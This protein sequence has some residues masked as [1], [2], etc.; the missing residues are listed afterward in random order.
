MGTPQKPAPPKKPIVQNGQMIFGSVGGGKYLSL[1]EV[2]KGLGISP[3]YNGVDYSKQFLQ[4]AQPTVN[5]QVVM[6]PV[7]KS[8]E[9]ADGISYLIGQYPMLGDYLAQKFQ[10]TEG[11]KL[12]PGFAEINWRSIEAAGG[13]MFKAVPPALASANKEIANEQQAI[14]QL[15]NNLNYGIS[16]GIASATASQQ[17]NAIDNIQQTIE[18]WYGAAFPEMTQWLTNALTGLITQQG[19][20]LINHYALMDV[21]RGEVKPPGMSDATFS[22]I[23]QDYET[24]FPGLVKYNSGKGNVRMSEKQYQDYTQSIMNVATQY[25]APMPGRNQIAEILNH[26]I[27]A[28]EYTQRVQDI[29]SQVINADAGTRS[30]L[31]NEFGITHSDLMQYMLTGETPKD[32]KALGLPQMQRQVATAEI[33]D[34]ANRVGLKGLSFSGATDLADMAKLA[35]TAGNQGLAYGVNQIEQGVLGASRDVALTRSLPGANT[36]TLNTNTLLASQLAGFGGINQV[37]AQTEVARAEQ[38]KVAP[39][40]KGGGYVE[41]SKGVTGLGSART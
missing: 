41:T 5:G 24:A 11:Q 8:S 31:K 36:P 1:G 14:A 39:F 9:L 35:G 40:E 33:Q 17:A 21:L 10:M 2:I 16:A 34:Y 6:A 27:S 37:A 22:K 23:K 25:G 28:A 38:A 3:I 26:H 4:Y 15:R 12:P 20:H 13:N 29:Y 32:K 7:T 19:D 30:L 18:N